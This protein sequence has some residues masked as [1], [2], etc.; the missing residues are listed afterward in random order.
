[1][2]SSTSKPSSQSSQHV[3]TSET[4]VR[5]SQEL[6]DSLQ[7]SNETNSTREKTL[8]L[9]IQTRVTS[10]LERI[11]ARETQTLKDLED[12]ISSAED[13][14]TSTSNT[15]ALT[16]DQSKGSGGRDSTAKAAGDKLRDLGRESVQRDIDELRKKLE[17]RKKVEELDKG[18][19]KAKDEVVACL[20]I[21]DRRP[22][23]CWQEVEAFRREVGR[24]EK[25]FV[26]RVVR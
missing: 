12:K 7:A 10:E 1:M 3:F 21:N 9:H 5:F 15:Q 19:E 24:L 25:S 14:T 20:R 6:V 11:Q 8:E 2:G 4:P 26:D 18:V 22:L 13:S 17:G 23:D 16:S